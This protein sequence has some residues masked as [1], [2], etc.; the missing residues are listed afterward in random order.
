MNKHLA[1]KAFGVPSL[2]TAKAIDNSDKCSALH[3]AAFRFDA[4]VRELSLQYEAKIAELRE[5]YLEECGAI[6]SEQED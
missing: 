4:R 6:H 3:A 2:A 1:T 5:A